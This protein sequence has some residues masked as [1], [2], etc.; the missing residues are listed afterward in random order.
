MDKSL[1][2]DF[3]RAMKRSELWGG[4][5][6]V[7]GFDLSAYFFVRA[8]QLYMKRDGQIAFIIPY[9]SMF[10]KPYALF[11]K[12]RVRLAGVIDYVS[13][14]EGWQ[15]G[16]TVQPL[17]PVPASVWFAHFGKK[18]QPL[19]ETTLSFEGQLPR[20]DA[21]AEQADE[22]LRVEEAVWPDADTGV[23]GSVY[24]KSFRQGAILIP[25]RLVLVERLPTG[26]LGGNPKA[27]LVRGRTGNQ[28][29][30]PWKD[31]LPPEGPVEAAFLKPVYLGEN[32]Y[33][34][35]LGAPLEAVIPV[36][37]GEVLTDNGASSV[38]ATNL[39]D[40]L[41][42]CQSLWGQHGKG[43]RAFSEQLD[44]FGQLT[45]QLPPA[46]VRVVYA[47]AGKNPSAAIVENRSSIID[48]KLYL[49]EVLC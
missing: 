40:W 14:Q 21:S 37:K 5:G 34:Y 25:R 13:V 1:K 43:E 2:A 12:G 28:D 48:H 9:A 24:R 20:R 36:H 16:A 45:S 47:K 49:D 3:K 32:V 42:E 11:R 35:R 29:K 46:P 6:S 22:H 10:K 4:T 15:L 39:S 23:G 17:F 18:V 7:S 41:E 33:P 26:R 44:Y 38:G 8:M 19:P 30:K 31:L 27:P